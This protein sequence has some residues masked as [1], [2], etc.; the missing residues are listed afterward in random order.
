MSLLRTDTGKIHICAH[1]GLST[2]APENT[3]AAFRAAY[4]SGATVCETDLA[5]TKDQEIVLLHDDT[6]DRTTDGKGLVRELTLAQ[7]NELDAG[8]W[9]SDRFGN[10]RVP[11]LRAALELA[12][13]LGLIIQLELKV[14][15][16]DEVIFPKLASLI[17]ELD[18]SQNIQFSSFDFAQLRAV[19]QH[20]PQ[21]MTVGISHSRHIDPAGIAREARLDAM[22]IEIDH[23]ASGEAKQLH[24]AGFAAFLTVPRPAQI[25]VLAEYGFDLEAQILHWIESGLI[26]QLCGDDAGWI[27]RLIGD[28]C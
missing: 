7:I 10:E 13:E 5:L 21:V 27:A 22:N 4:E 1:R 19:K 14:Y 20:L 9:F 3:L 15:G 23:F 24:E 26:D 6:V 11:T 2:H 28:I 18:A 12:K 17:D 16:Q 8:N 25:A